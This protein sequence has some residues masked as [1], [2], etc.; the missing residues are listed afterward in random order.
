LPKAKLTGDRVSL[1]LR[2]GDPDRFAYT[3]TF[4]VRAVGPQI[5]DRL[6]S[7]GVAD[8]EATYQRLLTRG[9]II[10]KVPGLVPHRG[11][12]SVRLTPRVY[13]VETDAFAPTLPCAT[14]GIAVSNCFLARGGEHV[15][16]IPLK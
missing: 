5:L 6:R 13:A 3:V 8:P 10:S 1:L 7:I 16:V 2:Q 14:E 12:L 9:A 4:A 15:A 11:T